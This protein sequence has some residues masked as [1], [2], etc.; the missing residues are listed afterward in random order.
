MASQQPARAAALGRSLQIRETRPSSSSLISQGSLIICSTTVAAA[1]GAEA[2]GLGRADV[3]RK[4]D[5]LPAAQRQSVLHQRVPH[6]ESRHARPR[7]EFLV[8]FSKYSAASVQR[9]HY[10]SMKPLVESTQADLTGLPHAAMRQLPLGMRAT[11]FY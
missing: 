11:A 10:G 5:C 4:S 1:S 8:A 3:G 2:A 9:S 7:R 6:T